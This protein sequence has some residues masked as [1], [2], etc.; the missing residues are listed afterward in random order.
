MVSS[1]M[2]LGRLYLR[3]GPDPHMAQSQADTKD[4]VGRRRLP[5]QPLRHR[6]MCSSIHHSYR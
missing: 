4:G 1:N 5:T 6:D 3:S 2:D